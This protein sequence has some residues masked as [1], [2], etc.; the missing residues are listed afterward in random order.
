MAPTPAL[1][2]L[3]LWTWRPVANNMPSFTLI[4]RCEKEA[5]RSSF[6]PV[7]DKGRQEALSGVSEQKHEK[8][9]KHTDTHHLRTFEVTTCFGQESKQKLGTALFVLHVSNTDQV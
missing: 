4:E 7:T 1:C 2:A 3:F 8:K 9:M 6:H 5:M